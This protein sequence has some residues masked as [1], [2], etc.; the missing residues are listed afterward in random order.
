MSF[1]PSGLRDF[2]NADDNGLARPLLADLATDRFWPIMLKNSLCAPLL[3]R[4]WWRVFLVE[5]IGD[6][7]SARGRVPRC[8]SS[9]GRFY[10]LTHRHQPLRHSP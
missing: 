4:F 6:G 1:T 8:S 9:W 2:Q 10:L 7:V 5:D 3:W